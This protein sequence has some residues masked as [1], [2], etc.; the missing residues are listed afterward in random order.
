MKVLVTF[1]VEAEFAPW[2]KRREFAAAHVDDLTIFCANVSGADVSVLLT[3]IGDKSSSSLLG[4]QMSSFAVGG[5]FDVCVSSGL[6]GALRAEH[7]LSEI[8]VAK[9]VRTGTVHADARTNV[10]EC[11]G[12]LVLLAQ[13]S[14]A[15]IVGCFYTAD[16]IVITATEK[17]RLSSL[18]DAVEMESF[19]VIKEAYAWGTR[20]VAIRAISDASTEDLPVDF[21]LAVT[22][23][24]GVSVSR[25]IGQALRH[26]RSVPG[27]LKFGMQSQ[28]AATAL[29][30]F[31]EQYIATLVGQNEPAAV[32]G[33]TVQA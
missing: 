4:L 33:K 30:E 3:G 14:G 10:L 13:T 6:S 28:K 32:H 18:A 31:L 29:A 5:G 8:L 25:M 16:H 19:E 20:A 1:A 11:D 15:K 27:L 7:E 26:P 2:R 9:Q 23:K 22:D 24:G 12:E 21:N 17:A